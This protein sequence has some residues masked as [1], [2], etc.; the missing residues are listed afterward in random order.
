MSSPAAPIP[1]LEMEQM[2]PR[3]REA[4]AARVARLGYLG[5][6][7]KCAALHPD[8]LL[9]FMQL[10]DT[11]HQALADELVEVVALTVTTETGN[12]YERNQHER[13]CER[14]GHGRA[15]IAALTGRGTGPSPL[16]QPE[17]AVQ[18]LTLSVLGANGRGV[19]REL[20]EVVDAIGP[21]QGMVVLMLIGRY[22]THALVVNALG[23]NPPVSS[24]FAGEQGG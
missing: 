19:S 3:L 10:T 24:I 17:Q 9:A 12:D 7:F 5:E 4:L 8:S 23:L 18:R 2:D 20:T 22:L 14:R 21:A 6:F 13:L 1:R 16:T 11:L 15:W